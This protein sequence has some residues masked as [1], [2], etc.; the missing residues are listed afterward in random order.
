MEEKNLLTLI[1]VTKKS[2]SEKPCLKNSEQTPQNEFY[3]EMKRIAD[4]ER[5]HQSK[6]EKKSQAL[7]TEQ[8]R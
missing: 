1:G 5:S 7:R 2:L 3:V 4:K 6:L 8:D